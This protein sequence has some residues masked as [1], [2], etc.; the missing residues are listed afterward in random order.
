M[1]IKSKMEKKNVCLG[2][3]SLNGSSHK[4][5][6]EALTPV[7]PQDLKRELNKN[8]LRFMQNGTQPSKASSEGHITPHPLLKPMRVRPLC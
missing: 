4:T 1:D 2:N 8:A 3:F 5:E 6:D 7:T